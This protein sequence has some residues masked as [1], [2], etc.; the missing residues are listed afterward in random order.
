MK[1]HN[2]GKSQEVNKMD[3]NYNKLNVSVLKLVTA[4]LCLVCVVTYV[5]Y[6]T[7]GHITSFRTALGIE[8]NKEGNNLTSLTGKVP[9]I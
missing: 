1:Q 3:L 5:T 9:T 7:R 6:T 2:R 4:V 8:S